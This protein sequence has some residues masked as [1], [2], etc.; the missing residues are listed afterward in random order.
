MSLLLLLRTRIGGTIDPPP[1]PPVV[2]GATY[3]GRKRSQGTRQ[4]NTSTTARPVMA[5]TRRTGR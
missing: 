3:T 5:I 1:E 2:A 4:F